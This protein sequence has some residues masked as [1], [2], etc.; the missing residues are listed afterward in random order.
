MNLRQFPSW[1]ATV[2]ENGEAVPADAERYLTLLID[3]AAMTVPEVD[4][5]GYLELRSKVARLSRQIPDRLSDEEKLTLS[6][7]G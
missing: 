6:C 4:R 3:G 1:G 2:K 7:F 5:E